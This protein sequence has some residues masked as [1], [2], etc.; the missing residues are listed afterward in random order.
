MTVATTPSRNV[1]IAP[2]IPMKKWTVEEYHQLI[3]RG[4]F[5]NDNRFELL[6]GWI[7]PKMSRNPPHDA[8]LALTQREIARRIPQDWH[9]RP[10][11]AITTGDSEP[12]LDLAVVAGTPRAYSQRHPGAA[13]IALL[14]EI[15]DSS[16]LDDRRRKIRIYARAGIKIY[17]IINLVDLQVEVYSDPI[18][19]ATAPAYRR[20]EIIPAGESV[21]L[22]IGGAS[23]PPIP[24]RDLLP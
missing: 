18:T 16:L 7:V 1:S 24:V 8:S 9:I 22:D 13:D 2:P 6:E 15:A 19:E 3:E 12:E 20:R 4:A 17:W 23:L 5:A 11:S 21:S 14:V 10:Q